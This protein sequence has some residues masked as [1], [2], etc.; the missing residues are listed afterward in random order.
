MVTVVAV[1]AMTGAD[2]RPVVGEPLEQDSSQTRMCSSVASGPGEANDG[3]SAHVA[4]P[5]SAER[6]PEVPGGSS[7]GGTGQVATGHVGTGAEAPAAAEHPA[8]PAIITASI[9]AT[10]TMGATACARREGRL[11]RSCVTDIASPLDLCS[12]TLAEGRVDGV[13]EPR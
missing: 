6:A 4:G 2:I 1:Y 9:T 7:S 13:S 10:P 11:V 12:P 3:S 5:N 8:S